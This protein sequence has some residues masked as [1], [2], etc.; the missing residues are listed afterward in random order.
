MLKFYANYVSATQSGDYFQVLFEE[1]NDLEA[2]FDIE[3]EFFLIQR[4]FEF[5]DKDECYYENHDSGA[6]DRYKLTC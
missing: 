4:Q 1:E 3:R 2:S 6:C 5:P